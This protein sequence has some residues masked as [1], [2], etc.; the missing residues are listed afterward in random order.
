MWRRARA[1][2]FRY[3]KIGR[4][5]GKTTVR[6]RQNDGTLKMAETEIDIVAVSNHMKEYLVGECKFKGRPFTYA[7]YLDTIAKLTPQKQTA[8]FF[9][10]LFSE[11][12]FDEKIRSEAEKDDHLLLYSLARIMNV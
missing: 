8:E 6:D 2:P 12:G 11:T 9:Y 4:W 1:L 10:A 7:E 3:M 5:F